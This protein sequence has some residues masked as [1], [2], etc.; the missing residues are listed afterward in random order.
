MTPAI[1]G[2]QAGGKAV[3]AQSTRIHA[4]DTAGKS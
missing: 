2:L 3:R 4:L 1:Y